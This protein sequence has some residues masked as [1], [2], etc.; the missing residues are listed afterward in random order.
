LVSLTSISTTT[1]YREGLAARLQDISGGLSFSEVARRTGVNRET[2]RRYLT[3]GK[4]S[5][6]FL[7]RFCDAFGVQGTWLLCNRGPKFDTR[8]TMTEV[9]V[10]RVGRSGGGRR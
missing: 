2:A 6:E 3:H 1:S 8:S 5:A 9:R 4:P 10:R 7:A